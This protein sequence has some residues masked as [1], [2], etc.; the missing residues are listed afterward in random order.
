MENRVSY[1][2]IGL[3]VFILGFSAVGAILW[4]GKYAQSE[5]YNYYNVVT[6]QSVS[7]LNPKAP[8]KL[9]GVSVGEVKDIYINK[10]NSEEVIVLI[11]ELY[12]A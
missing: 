8:V 9:R 12:R 5:N 2:L 4:L 7:G 10:N 1:I 3:F 6:T 11:K